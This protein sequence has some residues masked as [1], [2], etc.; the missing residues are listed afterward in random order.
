M[1]IKTQGFYAS[2]GTWK[3]AENAKGET[4]GGQQGSGKKTH[5]EF[6][7]IEGFGNRVLTQIILFQNGF[8]CDK[9]HESLIKKSQKYVIVV[10]IM[11]NQGS[12]AVHHPEAQGLEGYPVYIHYDGGV[13]NYFARRFPLVLTYIPNPDGV[14]IAL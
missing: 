13:V 14:S 4:T 10:K 6:K 8:P 3:L 1:S 11:G 9:C 2:S 7:A 5:S 12:Y